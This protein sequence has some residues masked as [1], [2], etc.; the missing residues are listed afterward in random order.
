[1]IADLLGKPLQKTLLQ[2]AGEFGRLKVAVLL[3]LA[4]PV[5]VI[6]LVLAR[7]LAESPITDMLKVWKP[8][9]RAAFARARLRVRCDHVLRCLA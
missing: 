3:T 1:M 4:L 2:P 9:Q 6:S 8:A 5:G 7:S